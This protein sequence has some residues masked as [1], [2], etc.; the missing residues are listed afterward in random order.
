MEDRQLVRILRAIADI[1]RFRMLQRIA[2]AG[3]VTCGDI[4]KHFPLSQSTMSHHLKILADAGLIRVRRSGQ[5]G[6][7]TVD[8]KL[9]ARL[10]KLIPQ[11][12]PTMRAPARHAAKRQRPRR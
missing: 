1:R 3:S 10:S 6:F 8:R 7:L 12:M 11:R 9:L 2:E 5:N 4:G